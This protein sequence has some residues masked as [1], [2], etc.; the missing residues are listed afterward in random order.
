MLQ[1]EIEL[2]NECHFIKSE[3]IQNGSTIHDLVEKMLCVNLEKQQLENSDTTFAKKYWFF[4]CQ[5]LSVDKKHEQMLKSFQSDEEL[6]PSKLSPSPHGHIS[7]ANYLQNK[8]NQSYPQSKVNRLNQS[9]TNSKSLILMNLKALVHPGMQLMYEDKRAKV[10]DLNHQKMKLTNKFDYLYKE[11]QTTQ[12]RRVKAEHTQVINSIMSGDNSEDQK[13]S[14]LNEL[15]ST[16]LIKIKDLETSKIKI[17]NQFT[18]SE[19]IRNLI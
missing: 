8:I 5:H 12:R 1:N 2:F 4:N 13:L 9:I 14:T 3:F 19:S 18:K 7:S 16:N 15:V 17:Y 11:I 10:E 6:K